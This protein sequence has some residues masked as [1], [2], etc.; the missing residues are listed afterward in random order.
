MRRMLR[1]LRIASPYLLLL[2][3]LAPLAGFTWLT[4]HP[5]AKLVDEAMLRPWSRPLAEAFLRRYRPTPASPP[6]D[7]VTSQPAPV[8]R[9]PELDLPPLPTGDPMWLM[10][11]AVLRRQP[12]PDAAEIETLDTVSNAIQ[13]EQRDDW[14]RVFR[15]GHEAW[16]YIE[17]YASQGPPYGEE[18][19]APG[20]LLG[21]APDE[22]ELAAA[23][24]ILG[25]V[26][27]RLQLG[28][29]DAY[30]DCTDAALLRRLSQLASHLEAAYV[31]R[32]DRQPVGAPKA[33]IVLY[34]N[35]QDYQRLRDARQELAGLPASGHHSQGL[36]A[37]YVGRR[38]NSEVAA[39]L[40]HELVHTFNRR[41]LGPA[42]P[43]WLDEGLA[44][45]LAASW[46]DSEG[47][48][49]PSRLHGEIRRGA[50]RI[51]LYGAFASLSDLE[52]ARLEGRLPSVTR[53]MGLDWNGFVH[54]S[55]IGLHYDLSAFW[56]R[57]L[58]EGQGGRQRASFQ[59]FLDH[60][61]QGG[62]VSGAALAAHLQV[63]L[64]WLEGAFRGWLEL[65]VRQYQ[66]PASAPSF[67]T[68]ND[69][70][71]RHTDSPSA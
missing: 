14:Y 32:Y 64:A 27:R 57:Y 59:A 37:F 6:D 30:T 28:P 65:L 71:S 49:D 20:P 2:L 70:S 58:L 13:L 38:S 11:G 4:H 40:I 63:D 10:P 68:N 3:V 8:H 66:L 39:T 25:A 18:P 56:V 48:L 31:A 26:P 60:V 24:Q 47:R 16:V 53:L 41:A 12:R 36:I 69:S 5:T 42:L 9:P 35:R 22:Q 33:A 67:R 17:D 62:E 44:D 50:G 29:Y 21:R 51:T 46:I 52:R 15:H 45:D 19:E 54:S 7:G 23:L 61:A 43:P 1:A 34:G 55:E